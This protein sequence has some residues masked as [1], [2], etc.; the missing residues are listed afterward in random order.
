MVYKYAVQKATA[1]RLNEP[2][3]GPA[4][5]R[6]TFYRSTK[7]KWLEA[8]IQRGVVGGHLNRVFLTLTQTQDMF[9]NGNF[10]GLFYEN[11]FI[12]WKE[13]LDL[14]KERDLSLFSV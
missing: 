9:P 2:T 8:N 1:T 13:L 3:Q 5:T 6:G 7:Q 11:L 14:F 4:P 10:V 12:F